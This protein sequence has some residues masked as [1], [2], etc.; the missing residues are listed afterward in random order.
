[1][2][3]TDSVLFSK[4]MVNPSCEVRLGNK[5]QGRGVRSAYISANS[6]GKSSFKAELPKHVTGESL[7][8]DNILPASFDL[9]P[10]EIGNSPE[11]LQACGGRHPAILLHD[12]RL[13]N[14][15]LGS[16]M[17][18]NELIRPIDRL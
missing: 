12:H 1:M 3:G 16:G 8:Y 9:D 11:V 17:V 10:C 7:L 15:L 2:R 18:N 13:A 14:L 4:N 6:S 5:E